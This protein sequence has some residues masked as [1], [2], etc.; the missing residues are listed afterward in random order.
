MRFFFFFFFKISPPFLSTENY[1]S[2]C[3]H[4][5]HCRER[6]WFKN[7]RHMS[8]YN[9]L[10]IYSI[11]GQMLLQKDT[12]SKT[13]GKLEEN[14]MRLHPSKRR[15]PAPEQ[16]HKEACRAG[17]SKHTPRAQPRTWAPNHAQLRRLGPQDSNP[18]AWELFTPEGSMHELVSFSFWLEFT[19]ELVG[20]LG[21]EPAR[22]AGTWGRYGDKSIL[23]LVSQNLL[24]RHS[25]CRALDRV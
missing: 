21:A 22:R 10:I 3:V 6:H 11:S 14:S 12:C 24:G 25:Y 15:P 4:E 18:T 1:V 20:G 5:N 23:L 13:K 2:C 8:K 9:L 7:N 16:T 17:Q 19:K